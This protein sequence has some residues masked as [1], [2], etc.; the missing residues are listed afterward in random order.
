MK[1][2]ITALSACAL[3]A[4]PAIAQEE[5]CRVELIVLGTAQDGGAPQIGN[6]QDPAWSDAS[7]R[8]LVSSLGVS[9]R[10]TGERFLF[11]A[12]PDLREQL[13]AFDDFHW[14]PDRP[15]L[16]GVFLTHGHIGHYT[17]L[18][19]F[20]FESMGANSVPVYGLPAM[21]AFLFSN[22]PWSQLV[23]YENIVLEDL[24]ADVAM[25]FEGGVRV[26][27]FEVPHRQE[28]TEVA[29][30]R[31]DGPGRSV[32]FIPD[33]DSWTEWDELGG[34]IEA[35]I[36]DV[37]LAFLDG[38]FYANG[39]IPG[40]DMSGFPHPFIT[41]SMA[42]FAALPAE[43]RRKVVFT[44]LNHTNPARDPDGNARRAIEAAG[45]SVAEDGDRYCL[46]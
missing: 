2:L 6:N 8:R 44:H 4:A 15:G 17:G 1:S 13:H 22:G 39:E 11:D 36:A 12:T 42:R 23:R 16:T 14:T 3:F 33:I 24:V 19:F 43:E 40:R 5:A 46:D 45:F 21:N 7:A 28:F 29:G 10:R 20:G 34:S 31:I 27:A 18:M 38:T 35:M 32:L 25:V 9:D 26:T 41:T 30:Y 37:D